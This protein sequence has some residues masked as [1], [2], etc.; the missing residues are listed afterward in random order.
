[1]RHST[2]HAGQV[3]ATAIITLSFALHSQAALMDCTR[4]A[5]MDAASECLP[6]DVFVPMAEVSAGIAP[7]VQGYSGFQLN[8]PSTVSSLADSAPLVVLFAT[9]IGILLVKAKRINTK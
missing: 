8:P 4:I 3:L 9:I 2:F 6:Q 1:M 5:T 7:K